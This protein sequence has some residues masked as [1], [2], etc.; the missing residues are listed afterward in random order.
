MKRAPTTLYGFLPL[1][2]LASQPGMEGSNSDHPHSTGTHSYQGSRSFSL[3]DADLA[4]RGKEFACH[5]PLQVSTTMGSALCFHRMLSCSNYG[6]RRCRHTQLPEVQGAPFPNINDAKGSREH[7]Y[8]GQPTSG[9]EESQLPPG[10]TP[11][12]CWAGRALGETKGS[13]PCLAPWGKPGTQ[14]HGTTL[15]DWGV[16]TLG[17]MKLTEICSRS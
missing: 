10:R 13:A 9:E 1:R 16:G 7:L 4:K 2:G 5:L 6:S 15:T 8:R 12:L 17:A 14:E 11:R 3:H